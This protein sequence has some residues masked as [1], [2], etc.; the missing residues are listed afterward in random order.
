MG[1]LFLV[2]QNG[3]AILTRADAPRVNDITDKDAS[4]SYLAR[5][6]YFQEYLNRWLHDDIPTYNRYG[7]SLYHVRGILHATIYALLT[8]LADAV[9]IMILKPINV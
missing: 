6:G 5:V 4:V 2:F 8:T 9:N 7:N 3:V 1:L